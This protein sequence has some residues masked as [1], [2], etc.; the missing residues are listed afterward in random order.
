MLHKVQADYRVRSLVIALTLSACGVGAMAQELLAKGEELVASE[1]IPLSRP[2]NF[3]QGHPDEFVE[4][5]SLL[6][7]RS[8][9]SSNAWNPHSAGW[10]MYRVNMLVDM[11]EKL[12]ARWQT[13]SGRVRTLSQTPDTA[14]ARFFS[15]QLTAAELD[16]AIEF[17]KS[18][19]GKK[20]LSYQVQLAKTYYR[21]RYGF[22]KYSMDQLAPGV[23][24]KSPM[25]L[26][27][28]WLLA[29]KLPEQPPSEAYAFHAR[30]L[31]RIFPQVSPTDLVFY[32]A[33]GAVPNTPAMDRL[34]ALL[35]ED[36]RDAVTKFLNSP[37]AQ[38]EL[39]AI[40]SWQEVMNKSFEP[41]AFF[42]GDLKSMLDVIV[43]WQKQRSLPNA[44][45]KSMVKID[46]STIKVADTFSMVPLEVEGTKALRECMPSVT[47]STRDSFEKFV[48]SKEYNR[49]SNAYFVQDENSFFMTRGSFGACVPTTRAGYPV[50]PLDSYAGT[51]RVSGMEDNQVREW[52]RK[53]STDLA[54]SGFSHSLVV[55]N[56]GNAYEVEYAVDALAISRLIYRYKFMAKGSFRAEDYQTVLNVPAFRSISKTMITTNGVTRP[57]KLLIPSQADLKRDT[58]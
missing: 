1:A 10:D 42:Q 55:A 21:G 22:E 44:L 27:K 5:I 20:F 51:I 14:L 7:L 16:Q 41:A 19:A 8:L 32:L 3:E 2:M 36:A 40:K 33:V 39:A 45:P 15:E 57:Q 35:P 29:Q 49:T 6:A 9:D 50:V 28:D 43:A 25:E 46:A 34:N 37:V 23:T 54:T 11:D 24:P 30:T 13:T 48:Q 18:P 38:K 56:T 17:Y 53:I 26:K 52:R 47:D 12:R 58:D 4:L 31:Q